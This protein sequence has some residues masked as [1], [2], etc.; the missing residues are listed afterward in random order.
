MDEPNGISNDQESEES[1]ARYLWLLSLCI[2]LAVG[3]GIGAAIGSIGAGIGLGMA[4]GVAVGL[5]FYQW[6]KRKDKGE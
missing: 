6:V 5:I 4:V 3:A 2:G 1:I